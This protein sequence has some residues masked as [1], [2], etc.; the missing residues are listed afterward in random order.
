MDRPCTSSWIGAHENFQDRDY[1][2]GSSQV[3]QRRD[4]GQLEKRPAQILKYLEQLMK[5]Q[6]DA[7]LYNVIGP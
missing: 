2:A 5:H 4:N 6:V 3:S 1:D 7:H